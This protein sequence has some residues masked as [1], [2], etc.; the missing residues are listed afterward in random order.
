MLLPGRPTHHRGASDTPDTRE[1]EYHHVVSQVRGRGRFAASLIAS[2]G[3]VAAAGAVTT[4]PAQSVPPTGDCATAYPGR[5]P[6]AG[7]HRSMG[8]RW[9]RGITPTGFTGEVIGVLKDG[10]GPGKSMVMVDLDMPEILQD[11]R[12]LVRACPGLRCTP[13]SGRLIGAVAYGLS[14]GA[15]PDRGHH[16]VRVHG[17]L[18]ARRGPGGQGGRR[19]DRRRA[20]RRSELGH[21]A[22]GG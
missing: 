16:A 20:D 3:A 22:T 11:R 15:V 10:I 12:R 13:T 17:R 9:S 14:F 7:R 6:G 5:R 8:A 4:G 1:R 19:Q 18:H 21:A 2:L